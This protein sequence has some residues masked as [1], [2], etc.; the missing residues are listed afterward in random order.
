[1]LGLLLSMI[2]IL[3]R[4]A[5]IVIPLAFAVA[6]VVRRGPGFRTIAVAGHPPADRGCCCISDSRRGSSRRA[7]RRF[8]PSRRSSRQSPRICATHYTVPI[9]L[10]TFVAYA[11]L[12]SLPILAVVSL[13][14]WERSDAAQRRTL[15][16]VFVAATAAS[17]GCSD[18]DRH[19]DALHRQRAERFWDRAADA[20]GYALRQEE[21]P[22][23]SRVA[24]SVLERGNARRQSLGPRCSR[25]WWRTALRGIRSRPLASGSTLAM[26]VIVGSGVAYTLL[27][28]LAPPVLLRP[29][30]RVPAA[31]GRTLH[32]HSFCRHVIQ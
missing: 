23:G 28:A 19:A 30:C 31:V 9:R 29:V 12:F 22:R 8:W 5:G 2:A 15:L 27:G 6:Y 16:A 7:A 17:V 13:R 10:F 4:Q 25:A 20:H 14:A 11:G 21:L 18:R 32:R 1:M 26:I 3:I 24:E